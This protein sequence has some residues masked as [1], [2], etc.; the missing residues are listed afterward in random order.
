MKSRSKYKHIFAS[1][2]MLYRALQTISS[3]RYRLPVRRYI[4]DLFSIELDDTV[5]KQLSE[6]AV[7]LRV[8]STSGDATA[9]VSRVVSIVGRPVRH[10]Q[11]SDSD[12]NSITEDEEPPDVKQYPVV[13][14]RPKSQIVGFGKANES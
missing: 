8:K 6:H 5:V 13:K 10:R 3:Q 9:R 14:T 2:S 4:L 1:T 12:D 11:M 7:K